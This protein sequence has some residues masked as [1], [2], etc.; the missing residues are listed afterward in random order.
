MEAGTPWEEAILENRA[1]FSEICCLHPASGRAGQPLSD[2]FLPLDVRASRVSIAGVANAILHPFV[3]DCGDRRF[4]V[5]CGHL[6][7]EAA[8]WIKAV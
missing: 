8:A 7:V 5:V 1:N 3:N 6:A 2:A 4:V